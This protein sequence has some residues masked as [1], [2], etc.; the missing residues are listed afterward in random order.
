MRFLVQSWSDADHGPGNGELRANH[1]ATLAKRARRIDDHW[2][3]RILQ[4][5]LISQNYSNVCLRSS[6]Q[7]L[8]RSKVHADYR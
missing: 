5:G 4:T 1:A 3:T 8:I 7:A 6:V 2:H